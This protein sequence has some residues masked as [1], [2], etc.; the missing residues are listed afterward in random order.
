MKPHI[1]FDLRQDCRRLFNELSEHYDLIPLAPQKA[2]QDEA[3][4]LNNFT[5]RHSG[6]K[7]EFDETQLVAAHMESVAGPVA[8]VQSLD[9]KPVACLLW[10]TVTPGHAATALACRQRGIPVFEINHNRLE[11]PLVGHFEINSQADYLVG[12]E[13]AAAN[14]RSLGCPAELLEFG[15]PGYDDWLPRDRFKVR[16]EIGLPP[17]RK[18]ILKTS[19]WTHNYSMWSDRGLHVQA[20]NIILA[21]LAELQTREEFSVIWTS[22]GKM[23]KEHVGNTLV[24]GGLDPKQIFVTDDVLIRDLVDA[25]DVV[26][27]Q[28]S[29]VAIDGIMSSR[30]ALMLDTRPMTQEGGATGL[31]ATGEV[32][33]ASALLEEMLIEPEP[34]T[35]QQQMFREYWGG[36]HNAGERLVDF[37]GELTCAPSS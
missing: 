24:A 5:W 9:P 23:D 7:Y 27:S 29:G 14:R 35:E 4:V 15:Q 33:T 6:R 31:W 30:P 28:R 26:F 17:D 22:R 8:F 21:V 36:T 25:S 32:D 12:S 11:T 10:N 3:P 18:Y 2:L 1:L 16:E 37:I 19:T 34:F 13:G 20:E